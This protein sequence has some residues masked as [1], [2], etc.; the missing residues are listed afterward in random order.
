M[1]DK[2]G[3]NVAIDVSRSAD[4]VAIASRAQAEKVRA[5]LERIDVLSKLGRNE[6]DNITGILNSATADGG[7]GIGCW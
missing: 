7:C 5:V 4:V 1:A 3:A 2:E 6:I